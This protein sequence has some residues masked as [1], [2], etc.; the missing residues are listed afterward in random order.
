MSDDILLHHDSEFDYENTLS[1]L[2]TA[3]TA[4]KILEKAGKEGL[5]LNEITVVSKGGK[6][7][8]VTQKELST[9]THRKNIVDK[10]RRRVIRGEDNLS[11]DITKRI[12]N[13][14]DLIK[15]ISALFSIK[16][17][18]I[19][20]IQR[21]LESTHNRATSLV[22]E[23]T[24]LESAIERKKNEDPVISEFESASSELLKAIQS[25]DFIRIAQLRQFC[26]KNMQLYNMRK[27]RLK[28]YLTQ[29]RQ[30]RMKFITEKRRL[31]SIQFD[32]FSQA[33]ELFAN[34]INDG[35]FCHIDKS[36]LEKAANLIQKIREIRGNAKKVI[37]NLSQPLG[38]VALSFLPD[39]EEDLEKL[40]EILLSPMDQ[41][42]HELVSLISE[43][44]IMAEDSQTIEN[45]QLKSRMAIRE[46]QENQ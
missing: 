2:S 46:K 42:V 14:Q 4:S 27:K 44:V 17:K 32:I 6:T 38:N 20:T 40:D 22:K 9:Q 18:E 15:Q 13:C 10:L 28:P 31:M 26:E 33:T 24:I 8:C 36:I 19:V 11:D 45:N 1:Q 23:V 29:A 5:N 7:Q 21:N 43:A 35:I 25:K 37:D 41:A 34:K 30:A 12:R 3:L 39:L 16:S